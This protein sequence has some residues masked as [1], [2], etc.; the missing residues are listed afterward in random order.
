M[1]IISTPEAPQA[2]G[3][4]SQGVAEGPF[5][6]TAGQIGLDPAT[7]E[8]VPGG[9]VAEFRR[10]MEN[11]RAI[12]EAGGSSLDRVLKTTLYFADLGDFAAVNE[13]YAEFFRPPYPARAAVQVAALPKG[14]RIEVEV[15][16]WRPR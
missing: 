11:V 10:A 8:M 7:G 5:L 2:I 1:E 9:V 12:L 6:F 13:A 14:A 15:V 16:A 3:P 4:Y